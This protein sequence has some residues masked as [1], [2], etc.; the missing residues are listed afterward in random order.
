MSAFSLVCA[1]ISF[2]VVLTVSEP[3]RQISALF[4]LIFFLSLFF[5]YFGYL[6][7]LQ[8]CKVANHASFAGYRRCIGTMPTVGNLQILLERLLGIR[9]Q[10]NHGGKN[11]DE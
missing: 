5:P 6:S 1:I 10:P 3:N 8:T 2:I 9:G 4:C 7:K 11:D